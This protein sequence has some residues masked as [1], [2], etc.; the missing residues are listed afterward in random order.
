MSD[1]HKRKISESKMGSKNPQWG[2]TP[3]FSEEH[4]RKISAANKGKKRSEETND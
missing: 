3:F 4:R 2:K 1:E